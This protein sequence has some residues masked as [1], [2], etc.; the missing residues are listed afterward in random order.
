MRSLP[1]LVAASIAL[2]AGAEVAPPALWRRWQSGEGFVPVVDGTTRATGDALVVDGV[3]LKFVRDA[4]SWRLRVDGLRLEPEAA[5]T[6]IVFPEAWE[7]EDRFGTITEVS[8][9]GI[10]VVATGGIEVP[11]YRLWKEKLRADAVVRARGRLADA[12]FDATALDLTASTTGAEM[13]ADR[14][15]LEI[16]PRDRGQGESAVSYDG[17]ISGLE[18]EASGAGSPSYVLNTEARSSSHAFTG[19]IETGDTPVTLGFTNGL[20]RGE[21]VSDGGRLEARHSATMMVLTATRAHALSSETATIDAEAFDFAFDAPARS[22]EDAGSF[23]LDLAMVGVAPSDRLWQRL[24]PEAILSREPGK[25]RLALS[26]AMYWRRAETPP[27]PSVE[28]AALDTLRLT[29]LGTEIEGGGSVHFPPVGDAHLGRPLG[30]LG[31]TL[32]GFGA[33]LDSLEALDTV[34]P[35][36]LPG[37]RAALDTFTSPGE[38]ADELET[39]VEFAPDGAVVVNGAPVVRLR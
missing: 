2:P 30:A 29:A 16:V 8:A 10:E 20:N 9:A 1:L 7:V 3:A 35:G 25:F 38:G 14:L 23:S 11:E 5:V 13:A 31:I 37:L 28:R 27:M 32:T 18:V 24:D 21:I 6:R 22:A 33:L 4:T 17:L 19:P 15:S 26:G 36:Q 34:R 12:T 39:R